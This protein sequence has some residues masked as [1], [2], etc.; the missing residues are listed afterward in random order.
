MWVAWLNL[1]S[2]HGAPEPD[3]ALMALF[4]RALQHCD[5]KKLYLALL[6]ILERL[7]KVR[8]RNSAAPHG[9]G[10]VLCC[11]HALGAQLVDWCAWCVTTPVLLYQISETSGRQLYKALPCYEMHGQKL[12]PSSIIPAVAC[13]RPLIIM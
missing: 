11:E 12:Q 5:Q 7:A 13:L 1:E 8:R 4:Q 6:G 2:L 3:Q 9:Q 10:I